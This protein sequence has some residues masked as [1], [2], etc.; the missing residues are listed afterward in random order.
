LTEGAADVAMPPGGLS[1]GNAA[2]V[3]RESEAGPASATVEDIEAATSRLLRAYVD[4]L[5]FA[6]VLPLLGA[7]R[8]VGEDGKV[9]ARWLS[10]PFTLLYLQ[11]HVR[12]QVRRASRSVDLE[13]L[14]RDNPD[15]RAR[16]SGLSARLKQPDEAAFGWGRLRAIAARLPPVTAAIP[17]VAGAVTALF[18]GQSVDARGALRAVT[19][20]AITGFCVWLL[21][22]W[23]SIRLGFRAKRAIFTG[24]TDLRHPLWNNPGELGWQYRMGT[25]L[26]EDAQL[27]KWPDAVSYLPDI[28]WKGLFAA[29]S[30]RSWRRTLHA[31]EG[32]TDFPAGN[33]YQLEKDVFGLLGEEGPRELPVDMLF[34][35]PPY[36]LLSIVVFF[37]VGTA[38]SVSRGQWSDLPWAIPLTLGL[39]VLFFRLILQAIRNH[40]ARSAGGP[41]D[42]V[43]LIAQYHKRGR[44]REFVTLALYRAGE[45]RKQAV[46]EQ[47]ARASQQRPQD[48]PPDLMEDLRFVDQ[49]ETSGRRGSA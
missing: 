22:V 3:S 43:N 41:A 13:L 6:A 34:S 16:L 31:T 48:F 18:Q 8:G 32:W 2:N 26:Y 49:T 40:R 25:R 20:L 44:H 7:C 27:V 42:W 38:D 36:L 5:R 15:E 19:L 46:R 33:I 9:R 1:E 37:Y 30:P 10:R 47:I 21:F 24:G 23:P 45:S 4:A 12:K 17:I 29:L 28:P 11:S 14:S 39:T 35:A